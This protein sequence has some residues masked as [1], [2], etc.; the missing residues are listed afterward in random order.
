MNAQ[1]FN[2]MT[3]QVA[4]CAGLLLVATTF[5]CASAHSAVPRSAGSLEASPRLR[6]EV[7]R[8]SFSKKV[9]FT[10]LD[11]S[12]TLAMKYKGIPVAW[13]SPLNLLVD[14]DVYE[15]FSHRVRYRFE[16][17]LSAQPMVLL[18][19]AKSHHVASVPVRTDD[20]RPV[21]QL[22]AGEEEGRPLG[23]LR[24]DYDSRVLFSGEIEERRVEIERVSADT[25]VD[26]GLL[27]YLLF[28]FP[29]TGEFVIRLDGEEA[30]RFTEGRAHGFKSP[31]ELDLEEGLDQP[32]RDDAM[33]AFVVFDLMK[34]FVQIS[35]S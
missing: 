26:R 15:K 30:G 9:F 8:N 6:F 19:R 34:D 2:Q 29:M 1:R 17:P 5:G 27:R 28:P 13:A 22:F 25:A 33:L 16:H 4:R 11:S 35:G 12:R 21:I 14:E 31:Y 3:G 32:T 24:Y 20:S 18:A 7:E 10:D 23:T